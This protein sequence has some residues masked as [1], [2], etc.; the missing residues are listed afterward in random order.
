MNDKITATTE[1]GDAVQV[2]TVDRAA[3]ADAG[4]EE[5]FTV[6]VRD[7]APEFFSENRKLRP[8]DETTMT[9]QQARAAAG[10]VDRVNDD[11]SKAPIDAVDPGVTVQRAPLAGLARHERI[12]QLRTERDALARR[13]EEVD[14]QLAHEDAQSK[15]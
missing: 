5:T 13:L 8:G 12:E 14:R 3:T 1:T 7:N 2:S 11:G 9:L 15:K 4:G 6:R 10:F